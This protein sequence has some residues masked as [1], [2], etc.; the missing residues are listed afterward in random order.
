MAESFM[1]LIQIIGGK[2][3]A[4]GLH[5]K[6][7]NVGFNNLSDDE[8]DALAYEDAWHRRFN[9]GDDGQYIFK[10]QE[11][12]GVTSLKPPPNVREVISKALN[13]MRYIPN[14][15]KR[16]LDPETPGLKI[17]ED[18]ATMRLMD[19]EVDGKGY[20]FPTIVPINTPMGPTL[21][22]LPIQKAEEN[23]FNS[24]EYLEFDTPEEA[25]FVAKNFS[26]IITTERPMVQ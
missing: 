15:V 2:P 11:G 6:K 17:G 13:K 10:M 7:A 18:V 26:N 20:V 25:K 9:L 21:T 3:Y 14:F 16:V 5:R 12:G 1:S 22:E 24:G 23:A 4:V 19:M 8:K